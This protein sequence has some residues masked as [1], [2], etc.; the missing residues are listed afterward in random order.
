MGAPRRVTFVTVP[1]RNTNFGGGTGIVLAEPPRAILERLGRPV[2][3]IAC[4]PGRGALVV[5]PVENPDQSVEPGVELC[6]DLARSGS[7][8]HSA[9]VSTGTWPR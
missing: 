8:N 6:L 2:V 7:P 3:G 5:R 1:R 4:W 9:I